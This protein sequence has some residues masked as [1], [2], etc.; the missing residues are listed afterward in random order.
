MVAALKNPPL[1][2]VADAAYD[3]DVMRLSPAARR[4]GR[5]AGRDAKAPALRLSPAHDEAFADEPAG[6]ER[7]IFPRKVVRG[8]IQGKRLNHSVS[9]HR[10]PFVHFSMEDLSVGG[11]KAQSEA[12]LEAGESMV[13]FFP[14]EGNLRGWDAYG[15]VVRCKPR[16]G[17]GYEVAL[18]FD[19]LPAA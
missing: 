3:A 13:V 5:L 6:A 8:H 14:P 11:L 4:G 7:R 12:P 15:R 17:T 19:P 2:D 18:E 16:P 1:A 10:M 9:A